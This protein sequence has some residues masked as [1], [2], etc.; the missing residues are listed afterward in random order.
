MSRDL[1]IMAVSLVLWGL[2]EGM[3]LI[4]QPLY[5]QHMGADPQMIGGILGAVGIAMAVAQVPAGYLADRVGARPLMWTAWITGT[6]AAGIMALAQ[7]LAAFVVGLLLY[8]LT[9]FVAAPMSTYAANAR[10][11]WS[12]GRALTFG[13]AAYNLGAILGPM[14]GGW[15]G[16]LFGLRFVY[17]ASF[18]LFI[19][20]VIVILLIKQQDPVRPQADQ[21]VR[22]HSDHRFLAFLPLFFLTT[23][24]TYLPQSLTPNYLQNQHMLTY[25]Q[26]GQLG[27]VGGVGIV[28]MMLALGS[29]SPLA[30]LL[31]GQLAIGMF[32]LL[33]WQ[34]NS[35]L[36]FGIGY[37]FIG[38][39]RL[40]RAMAL[41]MIRPLVPRAVTGFAFGLVELVNG[42]ALFLAPV[43]GGLL[44]ATRP[45]L[46]YTMSLALGGGVLLC[47]YLALPALQRRAF[48]SIQSVE[49]EDRN[50]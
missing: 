45:A 22:L 9:A 17:Q 6:L 27:S 50:Q 2:G 36:V 47:N 1:L 42:T 28:T 15:L 31:I 19:G 33:L 34:G 35:V 13:Q 44:Y 7:T 29:L 4:F 37:F 21:A 11:K 49:M 48:Q 8:S 5:L 23:L 38:G 14:I 43:I 12:V 3:F 18:I 24:V 41:A 39:Y 26:I 16:D 32:A 25:G 30:G 10:G 20:S 46:L 40:T